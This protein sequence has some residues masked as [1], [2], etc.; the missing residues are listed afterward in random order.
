MLEALLLV[1][2]IS[3]S[4][5]MPRSLYS[6]VLQPTHP[7]IDLHVK[8]VVTAMFSIIKA[9]LE[10]EAGV[11]LVVILQLGFCDHSPLPSCTVQTASIKFG[12]ICR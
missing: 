1:H 6:A 2:A 7:I 5:R 9:I 11:Q 4:Q 3:S 12:E 10:L 8:L